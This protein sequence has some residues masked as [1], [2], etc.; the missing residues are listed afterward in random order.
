MSYFSTLVSRLRTAG[1]EPGDSDD[2][3]LK[4]SLLLLAMGLTT[5]QA[6]GAAAAIGDLL[7]PMGFTAQAAADMS[8]R[9]SPSS[10]AVARL[11]EVGA[12]PPFVPAERARS[13]SLPR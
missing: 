6:T 8:H 12:A 9:F 3:K 13:H 11:A 5:A 7:K 1:I 10:S 2:L 4:K